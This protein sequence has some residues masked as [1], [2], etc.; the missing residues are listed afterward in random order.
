MAFPKGVKNSRKIHGGFCCDV[1]LYFKYEGGARWIFIYMHL[2]PSILIALQ[3]LN[4]LQA[5]RNPSRVSHPNLRH[6]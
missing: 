3:Y 6:T 4:V 1:V 5:G 2:P